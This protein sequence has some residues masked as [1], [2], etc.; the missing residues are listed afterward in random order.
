MSWEGARR[1]AVLCEW[2]VRCVGT[3]C[4]E[5]E[6]EGERDE[7]EEEVG[8]AE[9]HLRRSRLIHRRGQGRRRGEAER[10]NSGVQGKEVEWREVERDGWCW[11]RWR[12]CSASS[13]HR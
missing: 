5:R 9:G 11:L 13:P 1:P 12:C 3:A 4:E 10:G 6:E 7:D 2:W 8:G